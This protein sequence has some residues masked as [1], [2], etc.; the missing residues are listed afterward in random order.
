MNEYTPIM[1]VRPIP[2]PGFGIDASGRLCTLG[3]NPR[4]VTFN[5]D[6]WPVLADV[7]DEARA[8][9]RNEGVAHAVE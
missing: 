4:L 9:Q 3:D 2:F 6:H 8:A 5:R 1:P 7:L